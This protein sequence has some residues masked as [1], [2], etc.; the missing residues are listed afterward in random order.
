MSLFNSINEFITN[1]SSR[2]AKIGNLAELLHNEK[3]CYDAFALALDPLTTFGFGSVTIPALHG[4]QEFDQV[5]ID[6][7]KYLSTKNHSNESIDFLTNL[8]EQYNVESQIL[9]KNIILKDLRCG[10]QLSSLNKAIDICN[11]TYNTNFAKLQ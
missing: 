1:V 2:N 11:K 5:A 8:L 7:I 3:Y 9:I 4:N 10:A 6:G